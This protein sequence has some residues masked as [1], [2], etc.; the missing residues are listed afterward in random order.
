M[1]NLIKSEFFWLAILFSLFQA[2]AKR[3]QNKKDVS[4]ISPFQNLTEF[5]L[6]VF[7]ERNLNNSACLYV[8]FWNKPPLIV[9]FFS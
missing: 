3:K 5:I 8:C 2:N 4:V 7:F 1:L 6:F 9:F